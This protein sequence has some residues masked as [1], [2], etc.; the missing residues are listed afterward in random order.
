M[1]NPIAIDIWMMPNMCM[2]SGFLIP[3]VRI[4][5]LLSMSTLAQDRVGDWHVGKMCV[6][7]CEP[8]GSHRAT[9]RATLL[10]IRCCEGPWQRRLLAW[11]VGAHGHVHMGLRA[12]ECEWVVN[13]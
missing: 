1:R 8:P 5:L 7:Y 6:A 3:F 12:C 9:C 2:R 10:W 4:T 13:P 11:V